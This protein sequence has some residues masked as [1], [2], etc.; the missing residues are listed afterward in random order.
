MVRAATQIEK[1]E[2]VDQGQAK[3][4]SGNSPAPETLA[5]HQNKCSEYN[6]RMFW[7]Q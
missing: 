3:R 1:Q 2:R 7:C 4:N 5:H 6:E